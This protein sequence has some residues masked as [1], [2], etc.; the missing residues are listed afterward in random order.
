MSRYAQ[1]TKRFMAGLSKM[2]EGAE[3]RDCMYFDLL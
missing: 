2:A 1:F 3:R